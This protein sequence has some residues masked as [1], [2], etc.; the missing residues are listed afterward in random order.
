MKKS[1]IICILIVLVIVL[2]DI[3]LQRYINDKFYSITEKLNEIGESY[4]NHEDN[5]KNIDELNQIWNSSYE[6]MAC[7]LE[8]DELEKVKAQL[9]V[10]EAAA[11]IDDFEMV[12]EETSRAKFIIEH[13]NEKQSL[14]IDNIF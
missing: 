13:I 8:H 11:Q 1:L 4:E 3:I 14:R 10:M 9:T 12:Y 7:Y 5:I 2:G 6:I